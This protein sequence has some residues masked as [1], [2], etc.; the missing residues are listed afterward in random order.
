M[1]IHYFHSIYSYIPPLQISSFSR[2]HPFILLSIFYVS[3][4]FF[5]TLFPL[6]NH[7]FT[8]ICLFYLLNTLYNP[9]LDAFHITHFSFFFP[10]FLLYQKSQPTSYFLFPFPLTRH[11]FL[12]IRL[13]LSLSLSP[14][15]SPFYFFL[16]RLPSFFSFPLKIQLPP[17][18]LRFIIPGT[19]S[20]PSCSTMQD[21]RVP[22]QK[23]RKNSGGWMGS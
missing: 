17:N 3:P 23:R 21:D 14:F 10:L 20:P 12:F 18:Y 11:P 15:L 16:S 5:P 4:L 7:T 13:S 22:H 2:C 9:H 19:L 8:I 6:H 1:I